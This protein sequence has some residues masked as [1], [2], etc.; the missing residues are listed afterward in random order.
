M[1]EG[2]LLPQNA[3]W[4]CEHAICKLHLPAGQGRVIAASRGCLLQPAAV[5]SPRLVLLAGKSMVCLRLEWRA[6]SR[7]YPPGSFGSRSCLEIVGM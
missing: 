7:S 5:P 1:H 2:R 6:Y 4:V 3:P